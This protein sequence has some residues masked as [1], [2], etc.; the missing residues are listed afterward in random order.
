MVLDGPRSRG[1]HGDPRDFEAFDVPQLRGI[2][3]TAPYVHDNNGET[4]QQV[5]DQYSRFMLP[6]IA[7]LNLPPMYPPEQGAFRC[8]SR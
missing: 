7:P 5:L 6:A 8:R 4:L 2:A 3:H 1:D